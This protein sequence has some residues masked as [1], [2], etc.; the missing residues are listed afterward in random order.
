LDEASENRW[1]QLRDCDR[2]EANAQSTEL[3][4]RFDESQR[5]ER[6]LRDSHIELT[7]QNGSRGFRQ[8]R[9]LGKQAN[10]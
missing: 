9:H 5:T 8:L 6:Q 2:K 7:T 3:T 10:D 1:L 4:K